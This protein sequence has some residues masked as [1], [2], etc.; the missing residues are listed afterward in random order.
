M[1]IKK[2]NNPRSIRVRQALHIALKELLQEKPFEK[3]TVTDIT[4]QA[5]LARHT[6]YNHYDSKKDLLNDI[7]DMILDEVFSKAKEL[8]I[9]WDIENLDSNAS[10]M[11]GSHF[12][13][14]W[15]DH[16]DVVKILLRVDIDSL[17]IERLKENF[18]NFFVE[19]LD[20]YEVETTP[21]MIEHLII[22][23]TYVT[24]GL[25]LNWFK[26]GMHYSPEV[27]GDLL[28]HFAGPE[29]ESSA[30]NKFRGVI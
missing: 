9:T 7:I 13:E 6:F 30:I 1:D 11:I 17:L 28:N 26:N 21:A 2:S 10:R 18:E 3:I 8:N 23:N 4:H 20:K 12:F 29:I 27:M 25:L 15:K 24:V 22:I 16:A 19:Y 14:T 5:G